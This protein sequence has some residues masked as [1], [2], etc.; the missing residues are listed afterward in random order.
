V[1]VDIKTKRRTA[2]EMFGDLMEKYGGETESESSSASESG[3]ESI[4]A[5]K[6]R[7][8]EEHR[9]DKQF[10]VQSDVSPDSDESAHD[11]EAMD[12]MTEV[13]ESEHEEVA[14]QFMPSST[15]EFFNRRRFLCWNLI[16]CIF[17]RENPA[18][19]ETDETTSIDIEFADT[20][21]YRNQFFDN[22]HRFT[23]GSLGQTGVALASRSFVQYIQHD[24][25]APDSDTTLRFPEHETV[26]LIA[27]GSGWFAVATERR[28]LRIFGSSGLELAVLSLPAR[29]TTMLGGDSWLVIV[30][31]DQLVLTYRLYNVRRRRMVGEGGIPTRTPLK[32][33][34]FDSGLLYVVGSDFVVLAL[35]QNFGLQ[36]VPVC[37]MRPRFPDGVTDFF[38][39]GVNDR[40]IWG[41][42]LTADR[43]TPLTIAHQEL[44]E[45]Q[46]RALVVDE[47]YRPY[48]T[49]RLEYFG[50]EK[51]AK[52]ERAMFKADKKLLKLFHAAVTQDRTDIASQLGIRV[53]S[54]KARA[55]FL[56]C[57]RPHPEVF[58]FLEAHIARARRTRRKKNGQSRKCRRR[59][60][61]TWRKPLSRRHLRR[62]R[63]PLRTQ[64]RT[65][66]KGRRKVTA[67][68]WTTI[69]LNN[70]QKTISVKAQ[71]KALSSAERPIP[72]PQL[73]NVHP[74]FDP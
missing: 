34:G 27:C 44:R 30:F 2:E 52:K 65:R 9:L 73:T 45:F 37:E 62:E 20:T 41:V 1:R 66:P 7:E 23:L 71:S 16:G 46:C 22:H 31:F 5:M 32:W 8:K 63:T 12:E 40:R 55:F 36:W 3:P 57:A 28:F 58:G 70:F 39:V 67:M 64:R 47:K 24:P 74:I 11:S 49:R 21:R 60:R 38:C 17:L 69:P 59:L 61:F 25:W 26:D 53:L 18:T 54:K 50:Y 4:E 10:L 42:Y 14:G 35:V 56:R 43:P 48:L 19:E 6:E 51:G 13:T 68:K 72:Q 33:I 29:P 15:S